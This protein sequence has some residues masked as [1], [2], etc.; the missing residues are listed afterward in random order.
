MSAAI[1]DVVQDFSPGNRIELF[2][3][4][5]SALV[6]DG[7]A[8]MVLHVTPN[9]DSDYQ[10]Y[11]NNVY[12]VPV[13]MSASGFDLGSD[14]KPPQ[15]TITVGNVAGVLNPFIW[16]TQ[17]MLGAT[18]TRTLTL[19]RYIWG[20]PDQDYSKFMRRDVYVV[21]QKV[22]QGPEGVEF[23]LVAG[24]DQD[25]R[26]APAR[27]VFADVCLYR[28]RTWN[29]SSF[30]AGTCPYTDTNYWTRRDISTT[31]ANDRCGKRLNSC[32]LRFPTDPLPTLAFPGVAGRR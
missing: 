9:A 21:E 19:A 5:L 13:P 27:Q 7:D 14:G 16:P 29:G 28:Y 26:R 3:V 23:R 24:F 4:D 8:A 20:H 6:I 12:Y 30:D 17:D 10:V 2:D 25:G 11:W 15:P 18:V 32:K 1:E 22:R 31:A